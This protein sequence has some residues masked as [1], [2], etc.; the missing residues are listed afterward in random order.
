MAPRTARSEAGFSLI[1]VIVA[2]GI[3]LLVRMWPSRP[4]K[5]LWKFQRGRSSGFS[6]AAHL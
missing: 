3:M 1:E 2:M 5:Y 6:A 4:I